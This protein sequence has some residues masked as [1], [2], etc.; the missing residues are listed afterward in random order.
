MRNFIHFSSRSK[1]QPHNTTCR[2]EGGCP[3]FT[4]IARWTYH[5]ALLYGYTSECHSLTRIEI[6]KYMPCRGGIE[7][8]KWYKI[9]GKILRCGTLCKIMDGIWGS[10]RVPDCLWEK[11]RDIERSWWNDNETTTDVDLWRVIKM[12]FG[13]IIPRAICKQ[14]LDHGTRNG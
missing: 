8:E 11:S 9:K 3:L 2:L 13:L 4:Y 7:R 1:L 6:T 5:H 14:D 10:I 12:F